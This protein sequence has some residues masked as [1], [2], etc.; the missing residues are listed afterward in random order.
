LF[1]VKSVAIAPT[2]ALI[3]WLRLRKRLI[4]LGQVGIGCLSLMESWIQERLHWLTVWLAM[5]LSNDVSISGL[6]PAIPGVAR[7][8]PH[9]RPR[10]ALALALTSLHQQVLSLMALKCRQ[11][12]GSTI[13]QARAMLTNRD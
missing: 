7:H 4:L 5:L 2:T 3:R 13:A 6:Y 9:R 11:C 10:T 1:G 8:H 12:L